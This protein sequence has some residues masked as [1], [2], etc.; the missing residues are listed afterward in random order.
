M[1]GKKRLH[2]ASLKEQR[3]YEHIKI[4]GKIR[5]LQQTREGSRSANGDE[6]T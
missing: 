1:P 2:G 5:A 6:T 3:Q 4:G